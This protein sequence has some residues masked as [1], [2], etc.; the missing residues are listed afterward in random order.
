MAKAKAKASS[1]TI[2]KEQY[3]E[4]LRSYIV[5]QMATITDTNHSLEF[6]AGFNNE[7]KAKYDEQLSA[8]GI[9]VSG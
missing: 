6:W 4:Q 2:T 3:D 8:E 7:C 9:T 1:N 5:E